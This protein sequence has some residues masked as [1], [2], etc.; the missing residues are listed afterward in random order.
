MRS[1]RPAVAFI[2][3]R[4]KKGK[5]VTLAKNGAHAMPPT[6][7]EGVSRKGERN[8]RARHGNTT[9]ATSV[10]VAKRVVSEETG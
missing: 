9:R 8:A 4:R 7:R 10:F 6:R 3:S 2:E 5:T 1:R